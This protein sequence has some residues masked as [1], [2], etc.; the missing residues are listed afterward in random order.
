MKQSFPMT[1]RPAIPARSPSTDKD[2]A[3][4]A[5]A[6]SRKRWRDL[7]RMAFDLS[8]ETDADGRFTLLSPDRA[9]GWPTQALLGLPAAGL[10]VQPAGTTGFDPFGSPALKGA[11]PQG[12]VTMRRHRAWLRRADGSVAEVLLSYDVMRDR[13]GLPVGIRGAVEDISE[14][15]AK[16]QR[17]ADILLCQ[18]TLREINRRMRRA[19]LPDTVIGIGLNELLDA[20]GSGG[21][22]SWCA[23]RCRR[24]P[25]PGPRSRR[26]RDPARASCS[27]SAVGFPCRTTR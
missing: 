2:G 14:R 4:E 26:R 5:L 22:L 20:T 17:L 24:R 16:E 25:R 3:T 23:S 11:M 7:A 1:A 21:G 6:Q 27:G 13:D 19:V 12:A 8:F 10:V 9:F 15:D 18:Q